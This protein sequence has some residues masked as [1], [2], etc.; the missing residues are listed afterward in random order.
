MYEKTFLWWINK[1]K[2]HKVAKSINICKNDI[3]LYKMIFS[4][5][6]I[7]VRLMVAKDSNN[8]KNSMRTDLSL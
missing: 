5:P 6:N 1:I 3:I 8:D 7:I 4:L 2:K